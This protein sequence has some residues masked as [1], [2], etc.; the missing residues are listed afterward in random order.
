MATPLR[1]LLADDDLK[2][3]ILLKRFLEKEGYEVTYTG[4]G[5]MALEQFPA[6]KPDLVLLD[7]NMPGKNGFEVAEKIRE[8][9]H[10]VLIF[11]LSDRSDKND[12]LKGFSVKGNDYLA[13]PFYPEEL[14]ARIRE[15][16]EQNLS[17]ETAEE[18]Y[19]FGDTFFNYATNEIRTG[20][21]KTLITSRQ[22]DILRILVRNLN[23]AVDRNVILDV[24]WGN[25]SYANSLALN[26]QITYLRRALKRDLSV[27]IVSLTKKGYILK[28]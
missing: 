28:G 11:F 19:S 20:N 26:V 8:Q 9:D 13:K 18:L 5:T 14:L 16:F 24:I 22:A 15:R 10:N 6:V 21:S 12:R 4:N 2:Y 17:V 3:S 27:G 1:I 7:I 23:K 25:N